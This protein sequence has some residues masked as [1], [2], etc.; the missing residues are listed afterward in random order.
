[1]SAKQRFAVFLE[2]KAAL[3]GFFGV[4]SSALRFFWSTKQHFAVFLEYKAALCGFFGV[5]SSALRFFWSAKRRF[6]LN[7]MALILHSVF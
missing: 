6:A 4:Q 2:Y 5:Q 3:C 1:L 7:L